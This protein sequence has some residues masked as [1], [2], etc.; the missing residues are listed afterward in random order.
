M[1]DLLSM[2]ETFELG[3][4]YIGYTFSVGREQQGAEERE[5]NDED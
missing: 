4:M 1:G 2:E 5:G 3:I